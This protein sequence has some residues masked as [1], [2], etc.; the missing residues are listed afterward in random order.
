MKHSKLQHSKSRETSSSNIQ[1]MIHARAGIWRLKFGAF[2]V[3][4]AWCLMLPLC[5]CAPAQQYSIDWFTIDGGGGTSANAQYS[6]S[7]TIG[8]PDAGQ[9]SGSNYTLQGGFG[10]VVA[11]I[12][13]PGAPLLTITPSGANVII[14]WPCPSTGFVLQENPDLGPANWVSLPPTNSDNGSTKGVVVPAGPGNRFYRLKK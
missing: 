5:P 10:G 8:Q 3:V 2:L 12:Q 14:S 1:P 4:G 6:L 13:S 7:G 11:A 9:M